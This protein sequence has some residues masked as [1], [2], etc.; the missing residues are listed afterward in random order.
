MTPEEK[1]LF[2]SGDEGRGTVRQKAAASYPS[3]ET[4]RIVDNEDN[5][6]GEVTGEGFDESEEPGLAVVLSDDQLEEKR[7][8]E[9]LHQS[10]L[11]HMENEVRP[12]VFAKL[13]DEAR[14]EV[15]AEYGQVIRELR[16][17]VANQRLNIQKLT[18][19]VTAAGE[20]RKP[21]E[22]ENTALKL[23]VSALEKLIED[24][25]QQV[26]AAAVQ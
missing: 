14:D 5:L 21:L 22:V 17:T 9:A 19:G 15:R 7:L 26:S 6:F 12:L 23:Q 25:R 13:K 1:D 2:L 24:L 20:L 11:L 4:V 3:S 10:N 16:E 18:L 8:E